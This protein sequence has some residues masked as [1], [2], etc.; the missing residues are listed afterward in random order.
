MNYK[1][2]TNN[3]KMGQAHVNIKGKWF[4]RT[5][6]INILKH[7]QTKRHDRYNKRHNYYMKDKQQIESK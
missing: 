1:W 5:T 6:R 3:E 4:T 7:G 2:K